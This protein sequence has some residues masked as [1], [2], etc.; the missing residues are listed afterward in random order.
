MMTTPGAKASLVVL[1]VVLAAAWLGSLTIRPLYKPDEARYAEIPREMAQSGDWVTPRL[2]GFKYFEKPPLQYWATAAAFKIFGE[3]D[4]TARLWNALMALAGIALAF[5]AGNRLFGRP[6][7]ILAAALL[8]GSPLYIVYGQFNTLDMGVSVWLSAAIFAFAIAQRE[9]ERHARRW[10]LAGWA[11]CALAVLSKGLI[12]IVLP[13]AT[14]ALYVLLRRDWRRLTRLELLRGGALFL[15][16]VAPWFIAASLANREFLYFFFVQEHWLRFTTKMHQRSQPGWYFIPVLAVGIVPWVLVA[17]AAWSASLRRIAAG[18]FS[19]VLFLGLWA[20]VV[21]AFFS[22][23]GSKLPGYVLPLLP[24]LAVLA[25]AYVARSAGKG[26][27][28]AQSVLVVLAGLGVAAIG[29]RLPTLGGAA[30][31][32]ISSA[33]TPTLFAAAA[34]VTTAGILGAVLAWRRRGLAAVGVIALGAFASMMVA[35]AGHRVYAPVF[36][37]AGTLAAVKPSGEAR[38][39]TVDSYDHTV[40]WSLRRTVTMVRYKDELGDAVTWEP[41]RFIPDLAGFV[42][43]WSAAR[44]AYAL[45]AVRDFDQLRKELGVPMEELARGPR[46][47][48]V[49]KP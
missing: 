4:W 16:I 17:V 11:A 43:Q 49:R 8:A 26:L 23:S 27:L 41:G 20:V 29:A 12:G 35:L 47:V 14:V 2:N 7:G 10:M 44:E 6:A 28:A 37:V 46:Y 33:Y 45:F 21:F 42:R 38:F 22:A 3:H 13:V 31:R 34:V 40:P 48:I 32:E 19:P 24:A 1:L 18:S 5:Y 15:V 39:F 25:G 30:L 36:S 9:G